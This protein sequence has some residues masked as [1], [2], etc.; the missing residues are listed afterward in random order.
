MKTWFIGVM[1]LSAAVIS[2]C[3]SPSAP[4]TQAGTGKGH[5]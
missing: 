2:G 4:V 3:Q 5:T 1:L